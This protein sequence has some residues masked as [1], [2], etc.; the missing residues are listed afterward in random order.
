VNLKQIY[1]QTEIGGGAVMH[2][3]G[4]IRVDTVGSAIAGTDVAIAADGEIVLRSP[5]VFGG[6]H[7]D[8]PLTA[9][10][11][12]DGWLH[13]GDSGYLQEDGQLVVVD[14]TDDLMQAADGSRLSRT[15]VESK[16]R[17]PPDVMQAV[18]FGGDKRPCVTAM[19]SIDADNVA[20]WA[21]RNRVSF[22]G[23]ADLAQQPQ[24]YELIAGH[25]ERANRDL[26]AWARVQR[27]V[28]LHKPLDSELT[29]TRTVRR[30]VIDERYAEIIAALHGD[31]SDVTI[32]TTAREI[33]LT[34]RSMAR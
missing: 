28:L 22:A 8:E 9:Q 5:A 16:L 20:A 24:V 23:Y 6:Y 31:A 10:V 2:R 4:D 15:F 34:I 17:F 7:G 1:G 33:T 27:F 12:R 30:A 18:V 19:I 21:E 13:T 11:L 3:D 32:S 29:R 14:R 26:P 25:V